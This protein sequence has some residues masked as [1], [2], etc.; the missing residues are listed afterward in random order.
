MDTGC[1][2]R[3]AV[4]RGLGQIRVLTVHGSLNERT[5]ALLWAALCGSAPPRHAEQI[6]AE[7]AVSVDGRRAPIPRR[8]GDT[9]PRTHLNVTHK[10]TD[11]L[12]PIRKLFSEGWTFDIHNRHDAGELHK[13]E[14]TPQ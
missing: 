2:D 6:T 7:L 1:L 9:S 3:V 14:G 4:A 12:E 11:P 10:R 5:T 13:I 8:A